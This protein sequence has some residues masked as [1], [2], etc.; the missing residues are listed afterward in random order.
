MKCVLT[1][2]L[3]YPP[4]INSLMWGT[5]FMWKR[6]SMSFIHTYT[7]GFRSEQLNKLEKATV[8]WPIDFDK[9]SPTWQPTWILCIHGPRPTAHGA[10]TRAYGPSHCLDGL[11]SPRSGPL[12]ARGSLAQSE[13]KKEGIFHQVLYSL[14]IKTS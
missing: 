8:G 11:D 12:S 14:S 10:T 3:L 1:Y 6:S 5:I 4:L 7:R 9:L 13:T 2:E